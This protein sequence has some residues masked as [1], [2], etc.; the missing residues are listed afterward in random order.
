MEKTGPPPEGAATTN[1]EEERLRNRLAAWQTA[2]VIDA[3]TAAR[4][5]AFEA[6]R[7]ATDRPAAISVSEVIAYIGT[8]V[9]LV[10]VGFLY[11][12]Q[13]AALGSGG[14][15]VIIGLVVAAG[16]AAGEL[17]QRVGAT[18]AARRARPPGCT[19]AAPSAP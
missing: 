18:R 2:G 7:P 3:A 17:V 19:L 12:T 11:G 14:R 15:L 10:G 5:E 13:Y 9:L 4:I 6:G 8:V 1:P 16:L